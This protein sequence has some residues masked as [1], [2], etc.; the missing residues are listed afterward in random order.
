MIDI[1]LYR[2]F[3][4]V[5][6]STV[7]PVAQ[8]QP[9]DLYK[10]N[11]LDVQ[12]IMNPV[13]VIED[14]K[15]MDE[16]MAEYTYA[17]IPNLKRY[18]F[19]SNAV[20]V[21]NLRWVYYLQ[22]D[23]LGSFKEDF[24]TSR[25]YVLRSTN[26]YNDYIIDSI[27]PTVPL[28][29][30]QRFAMN[31]KQG[32]TILG[33]NDKSGEWTEIDFFNQIY[34]NGSV[35]FGVTGQGNVSVD[36]YIATVTEFKNFINRV[37]TATPTGY[38]WGNLPTGVQAT[39]SNLMQY[40]T[41]AKWLPFTPV[42]DNLGGAI[43]SVELGST[44]ISINGYKVIAGMNKQKCKFTLSIP[45]H[46]L[47]SQHGYYNLLPYRE[48]NLFFLPIGNIPIDPT[49][50][51][52]A[53]TLY[54]YFT[55]D[56]ASTNTEFTITTDAD[57][58]NSLDHLIMSSVSTLGID[59]SLTDYS[60]SMEAAIF[61]AV[62]SYISNAFNQMKAMQPVAG[63]STTHTSSAG[64]THGGHGGSFGA[65]G[66]RNARHT[67]SSGATH[68]GHGGTVGTRSSF[69]DIMNT[70]LLAI[71]SENGIT[72]LLADSVNNIAMKTYDVI[73]NAL[74]PLADALGTAA[75]FVSSSFG[76]VSM[77]GHTGSFLLYMATMP[78]VYCWFYKHGNEDYDRF[79]RPY[80]DT[81]LLSAIHGFCL[82]K[83][84]YVRTYLATH[85]LKPEMEAID[86][87]LN[88]GIYINDINVNE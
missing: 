53:D 36:Y 52:G 88:S 16:V 60:L 71:D 28:P 86:N 51:W 69:S 14:T 12:S 56:L 6:N 32:N 57:D 44:N 34:T 13:I 35:V 2:G 79:G 31:Y 55:V 59:L 78:V 38:N 85:P 29:D 15:G 47:I 10:C 70:S 64:V 26:L 33:Y 48:V 41:F 11:F 76:Q 73:G 30:S 22:V 23:V 87:L 27:Y 50:I 58:I 42:A 81:T 63:G 83:N 17:Y 8:L 68:G 46:P 82:C 20:I 24:L 61:S 74:Q 72:G 18:Y 1:R 3:T 7:T 19:V 84:A 65:N 62:G 37:V 25:Q 77:N 67:S 5:L 45:D 39:L 9:G 54:I 40:I 21:D 66:Y 75:D 43:T 80:C 49:K 4:K